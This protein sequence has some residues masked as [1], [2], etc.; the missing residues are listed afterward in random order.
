[1]KKA[2]IHRRTDPAVFKGGIAGKT[3]TILIHQALLSGHEAFRAGGSLIRGK[4]ADNRKLFLQ[5]K[6]L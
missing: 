6:G 2:L 1:M 3:A 5:F 4:K